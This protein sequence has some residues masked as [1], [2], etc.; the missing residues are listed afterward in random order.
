MLYIYNVFNM[1]NNRTQAAINDRGEQ[2]MTASG[3]TDL[4]VLLKTMQPVLQKS[5]YVFCSIPS[6]LRMNLNVE[7]ICEFKEAE[8]I[9]LIIPREQAEQAGLKYL[10]PSRMIVLTVHSSLS[11]VGFLAVIT[12]KLAMQ[13]ISV[14][15]VSAFFH[16]Y[17]FVPLDRVEETIEILKALAS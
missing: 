14:N 11:A 15:A 3:E 12:S 8:G 9:T 4:K 10:Y 1:S 7:P 17:L 13:G 16:D 5:E 2:F 6:S